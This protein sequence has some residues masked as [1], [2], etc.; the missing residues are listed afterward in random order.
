MG[1]K[2]ISMHITLA[3]TNLSI[4]GQ[5]YFVIVYYVQLNIFRWKKFLAKIDQ[6]WLDPGL[7]L[8]KLAGASQC[9]FA[10]VR[11][12]VQLLL[13]SYRAL[14]VTECAC[15]C[16]CA[17]SSALAVTYMQRH[18]HRSKMC[19]KLVVDCKICICGVHWARGQFVWQAGKEE[20]MMVL[21]L[22]LIVCW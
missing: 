21:L 12:R 1:P 13:L 11:L 2:E 9:A 22:F 19:V 3:V 14:E 17:M 10:F 20:G 8:V 15:A 16:L 4:I 7:I 6:N 5:N 18:E